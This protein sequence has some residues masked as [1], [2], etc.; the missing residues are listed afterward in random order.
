MFFF[1]L[2]I[3]ISKKIGPEKEF[4]GLK[5]F[6][7]TAYLAYAFSK[8][9]ELL[10]TKYIASKNEKETFVKSVEQLKDHLE[11]HD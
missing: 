6:R 2:M 7:T 1:F 3:Q 9:C 5:F 11:V 4:T 10:H 8:L